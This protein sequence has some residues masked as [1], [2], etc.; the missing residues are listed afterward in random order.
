MTKVGE[1][2][3]LDIIGTTQEYDPSLFESV[4]RKIA[5]AAEVTAVSYTHLTL[6]TT[7]Y[8]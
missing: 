5:K 6:P 1:H 8:V 7:P 3:T 2:V 4:I